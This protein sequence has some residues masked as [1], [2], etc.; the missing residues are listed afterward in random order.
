MYLA[1]LIA[2]Y[3]MPPGDLVCR[4]VGLH[5]AGEVDVVAL[6]QVLRVQ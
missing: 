3:V 4:R 2:A 5:G 6:L 1:I